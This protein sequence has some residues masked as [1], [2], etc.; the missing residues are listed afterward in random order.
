VCV[1]N[2][3]DEQKPTPAQAP[4]YGSQSRCYDNPLHLENLRRLLQYHRV[5]AV[6]SHSATRP[7][8]NMLAHQSQ[9]MEMCCNI[10]GVAF[11]WGTHYPSLN[12]G[13]YRS[14]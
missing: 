14:A 10:P 1:T 7:S 5:Q 3:V 12:L 4:R 11:R 8:P 2:P 9:Q 6:H 13:L